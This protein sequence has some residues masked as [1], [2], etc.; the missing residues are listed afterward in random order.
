[1]TPPVSQL[2]A[3]LAVTMVSIERVRQ[4]TT[5]PVIRAHLDGILAAVGELAA[6][7]EAMV[8]P[9][10]RGDPGRDSR[11]DEALPEVT[12]VPRLITV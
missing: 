5:A 12:I 1:V 3:R 6:S 8:T 4:L 9:A 10:S 11:T 2:R 7:M